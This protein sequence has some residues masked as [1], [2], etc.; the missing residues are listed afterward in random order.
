[1]WPGLVLL[2][3]SGRDMFLVLISYLGMV[4]ASEV[5]PL[6]QLFLEHAAAFSMRHSS[7]GLPQELSKQ[8][9]EINIIKRYH[10]GSAPSLG[11][12]TGVMFGWC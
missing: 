10:C 5:S 7:S 6:L 4:R 3:N 11:R 1:M 9:M 8:S 2:K 12:K